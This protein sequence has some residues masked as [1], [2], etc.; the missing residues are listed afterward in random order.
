MDPKTIE[1]YMKAT[2][3]VR[4]PKHRLSTFGATRIEYHLVSPIDD[5]PHKTRLREGFV[6][7]EKPA[8]L[9]AEAL[10]ERFEGFGT[11]A[12]DFKDYID[13]RYGDLL[14]ALEY[15]FKNADPR[16][17]VLGSAPQE[18]SARIKADLD[19]RD[20]DQAALIECPDP[21]WPLALMSFTLDEA[22]RSFPGNVSDLERRGRF[23]PD[24][25][26]GRRVRAEVDALFA[27]AAKDPDARKLLGLN[28]REHVL[29]EEF[30][31]RFLALFR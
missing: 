14:R 19:A 26:A 15:R 2:R 20:L 30:E 4:P 18:T 28:L 27:R 6:V 13:A 8:V 17:S 10:E 11:E 31:D 22:R 9:T 16:T 3:L 23:D 7:S 12:A 1:A 25:G 21:A 24:G 5:M 29:M